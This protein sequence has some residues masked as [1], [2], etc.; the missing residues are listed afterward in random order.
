MSILK[1]IEA[2]RRVRKSYD[3]SL[4]AS[5]AANREAIRKNPKIEETIKRK[6]IKDFFLESPDKGG[7]GDVARHP[8][9]YEYVNF[10]L[11]HQI[12]KGKIKGDSWE[13]YEEMGDRARRKFDLDPFYVSHDYEPPPRSQAEQRADRIQKI[14]A[15]RE[16]FIDPVY[17]MPGAQPPAGRPART[18]PVDYGSGPHGEAS[19][20][21]AG[22]GMEA[23]P[24]TTSAARSDTIADIAR[25]RNQAIEPHNQI[26]E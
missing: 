3:E 6:L 5:L 23:E 18:P 2:R 14:M 4:K 19:I 25:S 8:A 9:A 1:Q 15:D 22:P 26:E 11:D 13:E 24:K 21:G 7:F 12:K 16:K 10:T 17:G 20:R